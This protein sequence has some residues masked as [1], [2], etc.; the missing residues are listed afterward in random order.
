MTSAR[1][2]VTAVR[3]A[4]VELERIFDDV[5]PLAVGL[6]HIVDAARGRGA[7]PARDE[8]GAL[9]PAVFRV[10]EAHR[11]AVAGAGVITVPGLLAD[12][13]HWLE[14][15]WTGASGQP[16]ALRVNLDESS[17]D[18]FDYTVADWFA[19]PLGTGGRYAAG[20]YVDHFCTNEYTIT[21][22]APVRV[23]GRP[24]GVAAADLLVGQLERRLV[25]L[26]R[27]V[28]HDAVLTSVD[29]RVIASASPRWAPGERVDPA[30]GA[31]VAMP[32][33]RRTAASGP[34]LR[35]WLLT[36]L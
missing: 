27:A 23:A 5:A 15:W 12:A 8:L 9:R 30:G 10:L 36:D 29:G 31:A 26:L 18:F 2:T 20:P 7:S 34:G 11:G 1:A 17:P 24:I 25:P 4:I 21:F 16:E 6:T 13:A 14:W 19:G 33:A 35:W 3:A 32:R 22:A 28:G